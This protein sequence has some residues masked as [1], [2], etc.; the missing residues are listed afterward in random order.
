MVRQACTLCLNEGPHERTFEV[1]EM[2][3][4]TGAPHAYFECAACGSVELIDKDQDPAVMYPANYYSF[5]A[6]PKPALK[7]AFSTLRD[8]LALK[9]DL[10]T[11]TL[12]GDPV[13]FE[14]LRTLR[15]AGAKPESRILDV[16]CGDGKLLRRLQ[17]LG[18]SRLSGADPYVP[19]GTTEDG[20]TIH[21][22]TIFEVDGPFDLI[23]FNHSLEHAHDPVAELTAA[24]ERLAP[25]GKILVR[26]PVAGGFAHRTYGASWIQLDAPRHFCVPT[27]KGMDAA[28]RRA[29]LATAD[30][31]YDSHA[32]QFIGSELSAQGLPVSENMPRAEALF[33]K[34]RLAGWAA[35][36]RD[37]NAKRDGDQA[38]FILTAEAA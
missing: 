11:S 33:G 3:Y 9:T 18:F 36:S 12:L 15:A 31:R 32:F 30:I 17:T 8:A 20:L 2:L 21:K 24:R 4:G 1:K 7:A 19:Q 29:G 28:A 5:N 6:K 25:G 16:G 27:V 38:A 10:E 22:K 13:G 26:I 14:I 23:M 34:A 37:L 35:Q